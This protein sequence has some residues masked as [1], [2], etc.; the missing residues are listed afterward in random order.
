MNARDDIYISV[1]DSTEFDRDVCTNYIGPRGYCPGRK[2]FVARNL[3][4]RR[5]RD[6]LDM[7]LFG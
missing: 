2:F 4:N 3:E 7:S 1:A 6:V 5:S